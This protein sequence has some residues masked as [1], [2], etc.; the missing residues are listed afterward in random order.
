M[1]VKKALAILLAAVF[2]LIF[3][4]GAYCTEISLFAETKY[5]YTIFIEAVSEFNTAEM[6]AGD[7]LTVSMYS[8]STALIPCS[9]GSAKYLRGI[10]IP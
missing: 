5:R 3:S 7:A 9:D 6:K 4:S 10:G 2:A 1:A 8:G